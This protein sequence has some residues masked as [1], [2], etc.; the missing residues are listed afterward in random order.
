MHTHFGT[1]LGAAH[2]AHTLTAHGP[3]TSVDDM[4]AAFAACR[5]LAA[6]HVTV[7]HDVDGYVCVQSEA[8]DFCDDAYNRVSVNNA[9]IRTPFCIN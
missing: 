1:I 5:F 3:L 9:P 6:N 7:F 4:L 8:A 2:T